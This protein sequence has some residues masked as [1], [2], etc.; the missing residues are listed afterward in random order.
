MDA[1]Q[2]ADDRNDEDAAWT[3]V[4][5]V[6]NC[7][8]RFEEREK[9]L[10]GVGYYRHRGDSTDGRI[11]AGLIWLRGLILLHDA[12]VRSHLFR[13]FAI[14]G[15]DSALQPLT[16]RSAPGGQLVLVDDVVWPERRHL[17]APGRRYKPHQ[18][19]E[20]YDQLVAGTPLMRPLRA[21]QRYFVD[22]R[23][24]SPIYLDA[25][26]GTYLDTV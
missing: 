23:A 24:E 12:E 18:R 19:D 20:Y 3:E 4:Q 7:L 5:H 26:S 14:A 6:L 9:Q 13:P 22:G 25:G 21:A 17:P 8:Y 15:D 11:V 1:L 2:L 10:D 16:V